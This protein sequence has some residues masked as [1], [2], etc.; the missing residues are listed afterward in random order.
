MLVVF[1]SINADLIFEVAALPRP[2]ETVLAPG[3]RFAPGGKGANQA[4]AAARLG[5]AVRFVGR[6][7][8]DGFG[9]RLAA[10]LAECGVDTASLAASEGPTG[11]AVIGVEA[12]GENLILVGSGANLA[13]TAADLAGV[14]LGPGTTL[15]CQNELRP[16]VTAAALLAGRR[17]GARTILNL[18]PAGPVPAEVLDALDVLIVNEHE[19]GAAAGAAGGPGARPDTAAL[20]RALARRHGLACVVTLGAAGV[21][22]AEGR[23]LFQVPA[24][25]VEPVD[26]TGAGDCFTGALAAALAAGQGLEPALRRAAV[27]A[28]LSC[29]ALGAQ[30]AQPDAAAVAA[31]LGE[32]GP[33]REL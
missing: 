23:R 8:T 17:A 18:A 1:G 29:L 32:L 14:P 13:V 6:I 7:G 30:S 27:A 24:L 26:T 5:A 21:L 28:A 16:E 10:I 33:T 31:R 19:A 11:V 22:A 15:L 4:A 12:G 25:P 2:G 3:Y 20:A 9:A